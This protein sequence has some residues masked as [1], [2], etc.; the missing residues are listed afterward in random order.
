M[1][2]MSSFTSV[3][4]VCLGLCVGLCLVSFFILIP[5]VDNEELSTMSAKDMKQVEKAK[6]Q[7]ELE[8]KKE[9][10]KENKDLNNQLW[11]IQIQIE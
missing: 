11:R 4:K 10:R 7:L 2:K 3:M 9:Q 6:R 1:K 5:L 8:K